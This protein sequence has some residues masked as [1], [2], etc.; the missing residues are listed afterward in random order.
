M[1]GNKSII[2][3]AD[4][5]SFPLLVLTT[6]PIPM[7]NC[8]TV[9]GRHAGHVEH[10]AA[11]PRYQAIEAAIGR[12]KLPVLV[13]C[14]LDAVPKINHSAIRG[15]NTAHIHAFVG[16]RVNDLMKAAG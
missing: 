2:T 7:V 13:Q 9:S 14:I 5:D 3:S 10:F 6:Y 15:R 8:G 1:T 4:I 12:Y 11:M 16:V